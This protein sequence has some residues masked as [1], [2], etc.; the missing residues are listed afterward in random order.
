MKIETDVLTV[1][2]CAEV[3]SNALKLVG[4]LDRNLYVRTN[5]VLEAA[6]GKWNR[7]VGAHVFDGDASDRIE[8]IL[9]TGSIEVPKDEF[10]F[11][12]T[13]PEIVRRLMELA[14]VEPGMRALEPEAGRGAI[15][16]ALVD[17]GCIV[18]CIEM[19]DANHAYLAKNGRYNSLRKADFLTVA[20]V[21]EY[22]RIVMNP[23]FMRQSDIE[24]VQHATR[25]LAPK[26]CL[27]GVMAASVN[28][29]QN[30]LTQDFRAMVYDRGGII[31]DLPDGAF[32]ASGTMVRTVA[33]TIP[34]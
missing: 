17:A 31:E 19:M 30:R 6:G 22:D 23:P 15:A 4:Q 11:F 1:L 16:D 24:H 26:G 5:K 21:P 18:D 8:Q 3:A 12:A 25:F 34:A 32:K 10:N 14:Q 29:R 9:A 13:P 2:S 28:F 20:P 7:R 33:V 27:V